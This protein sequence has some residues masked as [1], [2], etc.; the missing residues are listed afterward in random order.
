[1]ESPH[2]LEVSLKSLEKIA[3]KVA[4]KSYKIVS[5]SLNK[6]VDSTT[7]FCT[8]VNSA[9]NGLLQEEGFPSEYIEYENPNDRGL[10]SHAFIRIIDTTSQILIDFQYKQYVSEELQKR[11]PDSMIVFYN[12]KDELD[13]GLSSHK[14]EPQYFHKWIE[15]LFWNR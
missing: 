13:A 10:P 5:K 4:G 1:M 14:I 6:R 9:A 12:S 3:Q 15:E 11:V 8:F 2:S 7:K